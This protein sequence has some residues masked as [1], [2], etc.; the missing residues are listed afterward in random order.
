MSEKQ[1]PIDRTPPRKATLEDALLEQWEREAGTAT[2]PD[3]YLETREGKPTPAQRAHRNLY[4]A[5]NQR[6][7]L[8]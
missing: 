7:R 6:D 4:V 2:N 8:S 1:P 3:E 5:F